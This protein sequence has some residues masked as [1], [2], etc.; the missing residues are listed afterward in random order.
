[1]ARCTD[2]EHIISKLMT[3]EEWRELGNM[4]YEFAMVRHAREHMNEIPDDPALGDFYFCDYSGEERI[5][6][7]QGSHWEEVAGGEE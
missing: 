1:M 4:A 7:W 3:E 5:I 6:M 2:P